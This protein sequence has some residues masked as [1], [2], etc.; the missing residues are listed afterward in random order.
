MSIIDLLHFSNGKNIYKKA[1]EQYEINYPSH[2]NILIADRLKPNAIQTK[3]DDPDYK[4]K[5]TVS[6]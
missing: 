1:L 4:N 2:Q 3:S 6:K 5:H